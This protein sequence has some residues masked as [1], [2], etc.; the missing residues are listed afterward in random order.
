MLR[1]VLQHCRTTY[2]MARILE[3]DQSTVVRKLK[4][5]NLQFF[6]EKMHKN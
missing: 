3:V 2:E 1:Q 4:K 5:Y 6:D